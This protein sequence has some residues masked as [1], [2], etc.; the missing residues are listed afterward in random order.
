[1]DKQ[2]PLTIAHFVPEVRSWRAEQERR[3]GGRIS[4]GLVPTMGYL[5][6]GHL[7]LVRRAR[8]END[9]VAVSI[10]VNPAQF[11]APS[12]LESY[13]RDIER[14]LALLR[15]GGCDVVLIPPPE[16]MYPPGFQTWVEP[17]GVAA[18]LE[19]AHRPGHFRGVAT[20]VLKLFGIFEPARSYFGL[21]D[22][23]QL[24]VIRTMVRDLDVPVEIVGCPTLREP[25]GLAMSSRNA[26]LG[27]EDRAAA[28]VLHRALSA[29]RERW[30][31]GEV[32]AEILRDAMRTV[33]AGESR[34][35]LEYASVADALTL[36]ELETVRGP[37]LLSLAVRVGPVRLID[38]VVLAL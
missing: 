2:T 4:L 14:D 37:A 6:E 5:H 1:M 28:T 19:G 11:N 20:V 31:G 36:A 24:A 21:K 15:A 34:A 16:A 33:I 17:G 22:Y 18:P 10:F 12:D 13:P 25:D 27:P 7:S 29:A 8:A 26:R 9:R 3:A 35:Q 23:Q 38:N 32:D 30:E